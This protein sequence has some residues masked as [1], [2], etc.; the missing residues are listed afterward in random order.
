MTLAPLMQMPLS[1]QI[2]VAAALTAVLLG[3]FV[4]LRPRRDRLHKIGG[5]LWVVAMAVTALSSFWITGLAVLGPFGPIHLLS[6]LTLWSLW[7]GMRHAVAREIEAHRIVFRN[8]YCRGLL[9]AGLITFLPGRRMNAVLF[10]EA[11]EL[12]YWLI[13]CV[14]GAVLIW[15]LVNAARDR[16]L[17]GLLRPAR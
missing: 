6:V 13:G 1:V 16:G 2:H 15:R 3:P 8:L 11:S 14:G 9:V 12:G 7:A 5:Y 10:G 4:I 17:S